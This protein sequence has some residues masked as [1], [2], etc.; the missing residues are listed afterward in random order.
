MLVSFN[1]IISHFVLHLIKLNKVIESPKPAIIFQERAADIFPTHASL[2]D[3][4]E[5]RGCELVLD[6]LVENRGLCFQYGVL[7][8]KTFIIQPSLCSPLNSITNT[9]GGPDKESRKYGASAWD[10][11]K[12]LLVRTLSVG[13]S[14]AVPT[15]DCLAQAHVVQKYFLHNVHCHPYVATALG[16]SFLYPSQQRESVLEMSNISTLAPKGSMLTHY[17][18]V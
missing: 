6:G 5:S 1:N 11:A 9:D 14:S 17:I 13:D 7:R 18:H 3:A 10:G 4:Y 8:P 15:H 16:L 2:I 12:G